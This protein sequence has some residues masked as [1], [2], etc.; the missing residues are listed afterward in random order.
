[1]NDA[2]PINRPVASLQE[3][4]KTELG[5][6]VGNQSMKI[7]LPVLA[8][9]M[10]IAAIAFGRVP[11]PML[12]A[13]LVAIMA[14]HVTRLTILRRVLADPRVALNRRIHFAVSISWASGL[15]NASSVFFLPYLPLHLQAIHSVI[16]L[17]LCAGCVAVNVGHLGIV[18]GFLA[19]II[20]ALASFWL[21]QA[22]GAAGWEAAAVAG[23]MV[24]FGFTLLFLSRDTWHTFERS[25]AIRLE[26]T[27]LARRLEAAL[28]RAETASRS[29]TRFLASASHDLRQPLH[30]LSLNAAA[31]AF[32]PLDER[33]REIVRDMGEA[34]EDLSYEL[35]SLLDISKLDAG[36]VPV[37]PAMFEFTS[38]LSRICQSFDAIAKARA[39]HFR[40]S[41]PEEIY[42]ST[43]RKL[44]EGILR[45]LLDNAFKYT[46][47]GTV[48]VDAREENGRCIVAISDTGVGIPAAEHER[49]FE[50]FYQIDNP[51]RDRRKGL[52]LGLPIVRRHS[53]LLGIPIRM[54]SEPGDGTTFTLELPVVPAPLQRTAAAIGLIPAFQDRQF[55]VIDDEKGS[56][57]AM[58]SYLQALGCQVSVAATITEATAL[59]QVQEPDLVIADFRLRGTETGLQAIAA[60]R[61]T[62]PELPALLITGETAPERLAE[63]VATRIPLLHKPVP[64]AVLIDNIANLLHT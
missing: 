23:L 18:L 2:A 32:R 14:I 37:K 44:L 46:S 6:I 58:Q 8:A 50:E 35:D 56:R 30:S 34:L 10:L 57:E 63:M 13:W 3:L 48:R 33:G 28:Q 38:C 25:V 60:L 42:V 64:P 62:L 1:M 20:T 4:L 49:V 19:P 40:T 12:A 7:M 22:G 61:R 53:E 27:E 45:N 17:G 39:L 43:D 26:N 29:K 51:E 5:A 59:A 15:I 21:V 16:L 9:Q 47:F 55:L 36:V 52:G 24:F 31:L 41:W 11:V 54:K